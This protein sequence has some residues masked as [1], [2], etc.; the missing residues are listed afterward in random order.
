MWGDRL[1]M[2]RE[3]DKL[4]ASKASPSGTKRQV[5]KRSKKE[6]K[7]KTR[8]HRERISKR[9]WKEKEKK[10]PAS[11][12]LPAGIGRFKTYRAK[13]FACCSAGRRQNLP[14][15]TRSRLQNHARSVSSMGSIK[16]YPFCNAT[17]A[18]SPTTTSRSGR[19]RRLPARNFAL[20][21][22]RCAVLQS[23]TF[24]PISREAVWQ[25]CLRCFVL[26]VYELQ[27]DYG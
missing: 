19:G 21:G 12:V 4:L 2:A 27:Q 25:T 16:V 9:Q 14:R 18:S 6:K 11:P 3:N 23:D 22:A 20:C 26:L 15:R 17:E 8:V 7:K 13:N 1:A 24:L 10:T 5:S